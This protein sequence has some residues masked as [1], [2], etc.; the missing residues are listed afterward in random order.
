MFTSVA[1]PVKWLSEFDPFGLVTF[2]NSRGAA[3]GN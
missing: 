1:A 2:Q 3:L